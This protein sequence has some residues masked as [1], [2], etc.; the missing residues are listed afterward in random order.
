MSLKINTQA[1]KIFAENLGIYGGKMIQ[2]STDYVFDGL[3]NKP[4]KINDI[5]NPLNFYGMTKSL[6]ED[7][8]KEIFKGKELGHIIRTS[9][10]ISSV[11]ENFV[12][13]MLSLHS[14]MSEIKIINDQIGCPTSTKTV[15]ESC[16]KLIDRRMSKVPDI[17]QILHCSDLGEGSWFDLASSIG[18]IGTHLDLIKKPA[19]TIPIKTR[20]YK[21]L[22][23][24][25]H[26]SVLDCEKTYNLL[27]L[28]PSHWK[29]N[30]IQ[31]ME[32]LKHRNS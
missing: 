30:L 25:P 15:A 2:I 7:H 16:W 17:P 14:K 20:E 3:S 21:S 13:K 4:Y 29:E 28:S 9:W 32:E 1:P 6:A 18:E 19:K 24:R 27:D 26:Y 31:I 5:K 11:G 23:K 12:L 10:L 8:L 22:A